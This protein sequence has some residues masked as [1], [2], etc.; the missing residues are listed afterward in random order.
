MSAEFFSLQNDIRYNIKLLYDAP[1]TFNHETYGMKENFTV[2]IEGVE[3]VIS[4]KQ[5]SKLAKALCAGN[6]G[7]IFTVFKE[8]DGNNRYPFTIIKGEAPIKPTEENKEKARA[9]LMPPTQAPATDWDLKEDLTNLRIEKSICLKIAC[10]GMGGGVEWTPKDKAGIEDKFQFLMNVTNNDLELILRKLQTA[11][12]GFHLIA[13]WNKYKALWTRVLSENDLKEAV[14]EMKR[15]H[16]AFVKDQP[17]KD[18]VTKP[19]PSNVSPL[20]DDDEPL[21]F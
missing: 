8:N 2:E 21:P 20:P 5:G 6:T 11:R 19:A 15:L 7:D 1:N 10:E 18:P 17:V 14:A 4:Q 16:D 13:M 12:N 9:D 3:R